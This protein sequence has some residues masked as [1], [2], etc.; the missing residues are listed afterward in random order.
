[1]WTGE[2]VELLINQYEETTCLYDTTAKKIIYIYIYIYHNR[3]AETKVLD[4]IAS[5]L[6]T[7]G[8]SIIVTTPPC[9]YILLLFC[10][11]LYS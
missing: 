6:S 8:M 1:M 7:T 9:A 3:D 10:S 2:L 11:T 4:E 5:N